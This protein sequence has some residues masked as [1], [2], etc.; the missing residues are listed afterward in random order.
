[1]LVQCANMLKRYKTDLLV[2][3]EPL[4][5]PSSALKRLGAGSKVIGEEEVGSKPPNGD[6]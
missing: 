2:S 4:T 3:L 6:P 5:R 1:M